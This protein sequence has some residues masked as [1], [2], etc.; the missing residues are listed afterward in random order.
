MTAHGDRKGRLVARSAARLWGNYVLLRPWHERQ[1]LASLNR[2]EQRPPE[3]LNPDGNRAIILC[4]T[5]DPYQTVSIP[6]YPGKQKRLNAHRRFL[7]RRALELILEKS[8]LN[9]RILTR[10][11]MAREDFDLFEKFGNRILFGMSLPTLNAGLLKVYEPPAPGAQ[12]RLKTLEEAAKRGIPIYVALAP[13]HPECDAADLRATLEAIRPFKPL[14]IFH[15]PIN[16]RAE[17]VARIQAH[18]EKLCVRLKTEVFANRSSWRAY[19]VEQ[20]MT[21]QK[22]SVELG[23]A[24]HLHLWPDKLLAS[25]GGFMKARHTVFNQTALGHRETRDEKRLRNAEDETAFVEFSKWLAYWHGW[26]S[27]WPGIATKNSSQL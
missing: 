2:A 25:R 24:E 8:T 19:A 16:I 10:S 22:V 15:E 9:V 17:N 13:P 6:E 12:V 7:V 23:M 14:T 5:T 21:V 1:F 11:P 27:E 20:L 18:A 26:I 4:S 3:D